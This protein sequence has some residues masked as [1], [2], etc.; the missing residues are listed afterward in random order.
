MMS[1]GAI[2]FAGTATSR[3][4]LFF[5]IFITLVCAFT[6]SGVLKVGVSCRASKDVDTICVVAGWLVTM[7]V[8][9]VLMTGNWVAVVTGNTC[10]TLVVGTAM[11]STLLV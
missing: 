8:V 5:N 4:S 11:T 3:P 6:T 1:P 7:V 2:W 10:V 9:G